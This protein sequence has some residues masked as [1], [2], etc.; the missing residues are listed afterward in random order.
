MKIQNFYSHLNGYEHIQVHKP[1]LWT[2]ITQVI[3]SINAEACKTK[4]SKEKRKKGRTLYSPTA[5]NARFKEELVNRNWNPSVTRYW[6]TADHR[7]I[8]KTVSLPADEQKK[9]IIAGGGT[10]IESYNQ[11]DF[12]KTF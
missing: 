12:I 2:E 9:E 3:E 8:R 7:L 4:E 1:E 6:V 11:T 5:M 10:P